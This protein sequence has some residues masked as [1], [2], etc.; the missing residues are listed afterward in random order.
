[1]LRVAKLSVVLRK[2]VMMSV[3]ARA[4]KAK[5]YITLIK[6]KVLKIRSLFDNFSRDEDFHHF[7]IQLYFKEH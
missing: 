4:F 1:M 7:F 6:K 5:E 3:T 2:V